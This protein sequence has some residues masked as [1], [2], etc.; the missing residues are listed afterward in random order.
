MS[1]YVKYEEGF[2]DYNGT[3][4]TKPF[5]Y[6]VPQHQE[7]MMKLDYVECVTFS[8]QIGVFFLMQSFWNYLSNT[9]AKKSFMS[10]FEFR[11]YIVW[12][13]CSMA[14]FPVL[15]WVYREDVQKREI[16]PQLA[17]GLEALIS[18]LLGI[19]SHFRFKR[20]IALTAKSVS[21]SS[22]MIITRLTYF[23]DMNVLVSLI[24]FFY[25]I[26]FVILCVDGL[27]SAKIINQSKFGADTIIANA[28]IC[29]VFLWLLL[30][31]I[32]HPRP[33]YS[34]A[35]GAEGSTFNES[36]FH[37]N[38]MNRQNNT[39]I[40]NNGTVENHP[41]E[42]PA[43]LH[44]VNTNSV[45]MRQM[46]PVTVDY[47]NAM[48]NDTI[49]LTSSAGSARPVSPPPQSTVYS[50]PKHNNLAI[51]DPYNNQPVMFSMV[52][53]GHNRYGTPTSQLSSVVHSDVPMQ[54]INSSGAN[55]PQNHQYID[56]SHYVNPNNYY[57]NFQSH[58]QTQN[59]KMNDW[60]WQTP[61]RRDS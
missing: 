17:Y 9:V 24:L 48:S 7:F 2:L 3:I 34:K 33:Q 36:N 27:T 50:T 31:G 16:I 8:L 11:F 30:I 47:P 57:P 14:L 55:V 46:S 12:A 51:E 26:S 58:H 29:T 25:S 42:K 22:N 54:N 53:G 44:N 61:D 39:N 1:T 59:Q 52:D 10:S 5:Q 23:R 40:N 56:E 35:A 6:W 15:Q 45:F 37:Y 13:L 32:F 4:V 21:K 20:I 49:P 43:N 28:N 41:S 19:R 38:T 18:S 60:L